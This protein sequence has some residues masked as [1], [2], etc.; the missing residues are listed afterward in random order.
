MKAK[1]RGFLGGM[2]LSP[3]AAKSAAHEVALV[4][5]TS[6]GYATQVLMR[7]EDPATSRAWQELSKATRP[8]Q[9]RHFRKIR[10]IERSGGL[11]FHLASMKSC[12]PWFI[13]Q[14]AVAWMEKE[15]EEM[16]S[17]HDKLRAEI[18]AKVE[19]MTGSTAM[20]VGGA[21]LPLG[22]NRFPR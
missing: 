16:K 7:A 1:R 14:R 12:A 17:W 2:L 13:H 19:G 9:A 3:F 6:T 4:G 18:F 8:R 20:N 21:L 10:A 11:P 15:E 22:R 5:E